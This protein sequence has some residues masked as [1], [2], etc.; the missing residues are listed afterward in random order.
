MSELETLDLECGIT[1]Q[2]KPVKQTI[3]LEFISKLGGFENLMRG[4]AES[5]TTNASPAMMDGFIKLLNYF[6]G[7]GVTN[8]LPL[9][10]REEFS[11]LAQGE[12]V[13]RSLWV[14][15]IMTNEEMSQLFAQVMAMTFSQNGAEPSQGALKAQI[16]ALE[17][18]LEDKDG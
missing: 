3:A 17:A 16:A 10:A 6:T 18:K 13:L 5:L 14:R 8:E 15:D 11:M 7:W 9:D 12:R 1:L 4:G 2:L